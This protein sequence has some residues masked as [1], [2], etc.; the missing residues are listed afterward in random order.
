MTVDCFQSIVETLR[1][2]A[3]SLLLYMIRLVTEPKILRFSERYLQYNFVSVC[4]LLSWKPICC[5]A[6]GLKVPCFS[7]SS[8]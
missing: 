1:V 4:R 7:L 6:D 2:V 3:V 5:L 8:F